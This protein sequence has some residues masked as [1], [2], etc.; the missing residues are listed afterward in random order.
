MDESGGRRIMRSYLIDL[1][2]VQFCT[3]QYLEDM[4]KI[5]LLKDYITKKQAD[6]AAGRVANTDNPHGL[7]NGTIETNL[8][9]F[10][11]Y[12]TLYLQ[13]HAFITSELILMVR[14][15]DPTVNGLPL[16]IYCFSANKDWVSYESIQDEIME[17]FA[18]I[19]PRFGLYPFQNASA[20]D[21]INS[22]IIEA[23][24]K[25]DQLTAIP[26]GTYRTSPALSPSSAQSASPARSTPEEKP[27]RA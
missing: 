8:G 9:L 3:D 15:L 4:K 12:M 17:H 23:G 21:Y 11:A 10:R 14:T 19:L 13:Q 26:W 24:G 16:Q 25:A 7:V 2:T 5:D 20:R 18:A 1:S 27:P 6:Q 22:A